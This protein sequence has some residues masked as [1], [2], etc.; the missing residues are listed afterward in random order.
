MAV[1]SRLHLDLEPYLTECE[2]PGGTVITFYHRQLAERAAERLLAGDELR[3]RHEALARHYSQK[4]FWLDADRELPNARK[5][6]EWVYQLAKAHWWAKAEQSLMHYTFLSAKCTA[7]MIMDL[8]ADYEL[9]FRGAPK[10]SLPQR[11]V[12][13]LIA[14]SLRL[15]L[16]ALIGD[17]RQL[18][19]QLT[20][21]LLGLEAPSVR[22]LL[23]QV[24]GE[25]RIPWLRPL[26]ATLNQP[27]AGLIRTLSGHSEVVEDVALSADGR[28]AVSASKDKTLKV[29]D[30][31][32]G[33]ELRTLAGHADY[34]NG[35]A[36]SADGRRAV[37]ASHDKTLKMFPNYSELW[38]TAA[39]AE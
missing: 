17:L 9:V 12:L 21:R 30:L 31:D 23:K 24:V 35:V 11:D 37:S 27:G 38:E 34:V 32:T 19:S 22:D 2:A 1:W 6:A 29:W 13:D 39:H 28:R 15:S 4:P 20:G 33:I 36:V 25:T 16:H 10:A 26:W 8:N 3:L 18:P 5:T 7:G 14:G